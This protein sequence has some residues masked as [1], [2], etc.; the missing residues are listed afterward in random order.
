MTTAI[1]TGGTRGFGRALAE[2]LTADGWTVIVD[3]RHL[4]DLPAGV[5]GIEGDVTDPAHRAA[6]V[7][8]AVERGGVDLLVNNASVLGPSPLVPLADLPI[9]GFVEVLAVNVVAPLAL[10]Q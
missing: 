8:A 10:A 1:I 4:T 2:S 3:A 7:A 9:D 5:H 6:L